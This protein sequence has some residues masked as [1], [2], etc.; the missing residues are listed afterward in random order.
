MGMFDNLLYKGEEYQTKDTPDQSLNTY[1]IRG[2]ELWWRKTEYEWVEDK[3]SIFG[4][5]ME[6]RNHE[7][8]FCDRFDGVI[9]FYRQNEA[10]EWVEWHALFNNGRMIKIEAR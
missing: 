3:E 6:E 2:D 8:I 10:K 4:I 7:W 5:R 1:E 9:D